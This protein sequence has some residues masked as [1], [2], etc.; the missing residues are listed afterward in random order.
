MNTITTNQV[1]PI[2]D[3]AVLAATLLKN[4]TLKIYENLSHGMR[5]TH[6]QVI[7]AD[8]LAFCRAGAAVAA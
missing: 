7:N 2:A 4:G 8:L 1:V 6:A 3:S 5:T